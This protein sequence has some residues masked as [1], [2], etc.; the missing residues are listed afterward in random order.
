VCCGLTAGYYNNRLLRI[1]ESPVVSRIDRRIDFN[2]TGTSPSP[3]LIN[4]EIISARWQGFIVPLPTNTEYRIYVTGDDGFRL[5][6]GGD[7]VIDEWV[8]GQGTIER[9]VDASFAANEPKSIE[10]Q[11]QQ[12]Q[13][14]SEIHLAWESNQAP[15]LARQIIPDVNLKPLDC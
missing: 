11:W 3:G 12:K 7:L 9:F 6:L 5:Y 10:L 13:G 15:L 8:S 4:S 2:W 14:P 1:L